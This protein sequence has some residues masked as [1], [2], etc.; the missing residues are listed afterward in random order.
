MKIARSLGNL[1]ILFRQYK[2]D[3]NTE[4]F[5]LNNIIAW[6]GERQCV[7]IDTDLLY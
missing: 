2:R 4:T 1:H 5:D 7:E 3:M 6:L